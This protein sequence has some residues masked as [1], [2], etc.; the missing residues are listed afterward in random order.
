LI[1]SK[2]GIKAFSWL[3]SGLIPAKSL[4]HGAF[5]IDASAADV[6][7][8]GFATA[9]GPAAKPLVSFGSNRMKKILIAAAAAGLMT[10]GACTSNTNTTVENTTVD[11]NVAVY[12]EV[13]VL[14]NVEVGNVVETNTVEANAVVGNAM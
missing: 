9:I 12:N 7:G 6:I 4:R 2:V 13:D 1:E 10:L 8:M 14:S 11:A 5:V 3:K